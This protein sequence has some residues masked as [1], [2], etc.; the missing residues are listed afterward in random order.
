MDFVG[1]ERIVKIGV[2]GVC[3]KEGG[4]INKSLMCFGNVIN[5]FCEGGVK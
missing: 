2:G 1:L 3:L 5:K 4:Y